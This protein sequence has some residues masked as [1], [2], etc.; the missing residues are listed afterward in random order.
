MSGSLLPRAPFS[1]RYL[2]L[3]ALSLSLVGLTACADD[4]PVSPGSMA[5]AAIRPAPADELILPVADPLAV[6]NGVS[7]NH[8]GYGSSL[9]VQGAGELL[10]TLTDRGPNV[11]VSAGLGFGDP[12]FTPQIGVFVRTGNGPRLIGTILLRNAAGTPLTGL[13]HPNAEANRTEVPVTLDG[14]PL[15][16]DPDGIDSEGLARAGD[17]SFWISDEYGPDIL[18]VNSDGRT[19][20][21][22]TPGNGLPKALAHRRSNRGMEGLT[23]TPDGSTI[24]GI[25]QSPLDNPTAGGSSAGRSSRLARIVVLNIATGKT[26]QFAYLL[27]A[28]NLLN[29]EIAAV[30]NNR[31]LVL[32][33]DGNFPTG[34]GTAVKKVYKIDLTGATDISD[35]QDRVTGLMV[36]PTSSLT[37][38]EFTKGVAKPDSVLRAAGI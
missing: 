34:L 27:E 10:Y 8:G 32:E 22:I 14:T 28:A 12:S 38:E 31:F 21:R 29:S 36:G 2:T 33:R 3:G 16:Q 35:P 1:P 37:L 6:F 20:L 13:P 24:V 15:P 19:L 11:N 4:T 17:G 9:V 18:H 23:I 30:S 5:P 25:M 26:R 7:I